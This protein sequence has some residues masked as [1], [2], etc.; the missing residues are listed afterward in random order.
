MFPSFAELCWVISA[1]VV[2]AEEIES[3]IH[4]ELTTGLSAFYVILHLA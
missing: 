3:S 1:V 4:W 2:L